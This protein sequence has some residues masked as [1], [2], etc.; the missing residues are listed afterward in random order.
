M[1]KKAYANRIRTKSAKL[2]IA[3]I[4]LALVLFAITPMLVRKVLL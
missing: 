1:Q 3:V 4:A 2:V